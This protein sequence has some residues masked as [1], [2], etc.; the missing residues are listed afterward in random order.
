M[1]T[2]EEEGA[3]E[4][5]KALL[6]FFRTLNPNAEKPDA[7]V[8]A[9]A[10]RFEAAAEKHYDALASQSNAIYARFVTL[11]SYVTVSQLRKVCERF[12]VNEWKHAYHQLNSV[13]VKS[14]AGVSALYHGCRAGIFPAALRYRHSPH[15]F[16]HDPRT[17][18]GKS[19]AQLNGDAAEVPGHHEHRCTVSKASSD[20]FVYL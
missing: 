11:L 13:S 3:N 18:T 10:A 7:A 4:L 1:S 8:V 17:Y 6:A 2:L 16:E 14:G 15:D 20:R 5:R 9:A 12:R 19:G